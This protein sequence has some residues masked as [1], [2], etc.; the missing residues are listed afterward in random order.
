MEKNENREF[1]KFSQ[2]E[3]NCNEIAENNRELI[4]SNTRCK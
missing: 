3:E 1:F 2:T 4:Y